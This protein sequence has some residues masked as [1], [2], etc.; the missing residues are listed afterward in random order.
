MKI[1]WAKAQLWISVN[2]AIYKL[3]VISPPHPVFLLLF[4]LFL[5]FFFQCF[6]FFS[7]LLDKRILKGTRVYF[8]SQ[9]KITICYDSESSNVRLKHLVTS[10]PPASRKQ[11][12]MNA[13]IPVFNRLSPLLTLPRMPCLENDATYMSQSSFFG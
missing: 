9:F 2:P 10:Y 11:T 6:Y 7:C 12:T 13:Y 8:S 5:L 3:L 1:T 4:F